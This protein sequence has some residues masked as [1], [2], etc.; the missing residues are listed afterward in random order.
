MVWKQTGIMPDEL[1]GP[2]MP[3]DAAH[4]WQ[5]FLELNA[6]RTSNGFSMNGLSAMEIESWA[7]MSQISMDPWEFRTL[8]ALDGCYMRIAAESNKKK[9]DTGA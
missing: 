8:R 5:W 9:S 7:R 4:L 3:P 2:P 1:D 6:G